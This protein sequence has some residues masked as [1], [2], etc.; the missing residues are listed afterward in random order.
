MN[1]KDENLTGKISELGGISL[2]HSRIVIKKL[3]K[4][5]RFSAAL[6]I[7]GQYGQNYGED[8]FVACYQGYCK[9]CRSEFENALT[10]LNGV[11]KDSEYHIRAVALQAL[12]HMSLKQFA[13][14]EGL[15]EGQITAAGSEPLQVCSLLCALLKGEAPTML[16]EDEGAIAKVYRFYF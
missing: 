11:G 1:L 12:C 6:E 14:A 9:L 8:A 16:C 13:L 7:I 2:E 5:K 15:L 10:C 4:E 3:A